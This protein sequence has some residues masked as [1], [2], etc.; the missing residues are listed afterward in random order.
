MELLRSLLKEVTG[1][2]LGGWVGG[3]DHQDSPASQLT[4]DAA[5]RLKERIESMHGLPLQDKLIILRLCYFPC[6]NHL[7]RTLMPKVGVDG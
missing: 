3:P 1:Q 2:V 6:L 7:L 4:T 5:T